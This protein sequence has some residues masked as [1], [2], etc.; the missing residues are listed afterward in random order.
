MQ[1][2]QLEIPKPCT[3]NW[4]AMTP[5]QQGRF[6]NSCAKVVVDFTTMSD[7]EVL[8]FF[9]KK[10]EEEV[11]GRMAEDQIERAFIPIKKEKKNSWL[12]KIAASVMFFF[13]VK[14]NA[15]KLLGKVSYRP[16][17]TLQDRP[18]PNHVSDDAI[19]HIKSKKIIVKGRVTDKDGIG[20]PFANI[21]LVGSKTGIAADLQGYF[22]I[23]AIYNDVLQFSSVGFIN[24]TI[25]ITNEAFINVVLIAAPNQKL[26]EVVVTI[27]G[28]I[29][30]SP[31]K[32]SSAVVNSDTSKKRQIDTIP[33]IKTLPEVI[34]TS[35]ISKGA[36][37]CVSESRSM[38]MGSITSGVSIHSIITKTIWGKTNNST[39]K[40]SL[41][42][43]P[44]A[45]GNSFTIKIPELKNSSYTLLITDDLGRSLLQKQ[46][47]VSSK[48][49]NET[50]DT[51]PT[52]SKGTYI[53]T[54][55]DEKN[56]VVYNNKLIVQ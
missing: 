39:I 33:T 1:P 47:V 2:F 25:T 5:S 4:D 24:S 16:S 55:K 45:R 44:I 54:I 35:G 38:V 7:E 43:N 17:I 27:A 14:L 13:S 49:M 48:S 10:K 11:C 22:T 56:K 32:C 46:L 9:K 30:K 3:Q 31:L 26:I 41:F 37:K 42:P 23:K 36:I 19:K 15:Q 50:I 51:K 34:V 12:W 20:I 28:G 6:C 8:N 40:G 53:I 18:N 21:N 52:W 29:R